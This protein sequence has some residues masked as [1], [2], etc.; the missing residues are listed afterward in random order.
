[1]DFTLLYLYAVAV[2]RELW[3]RKFLVLSCFFVVSFSVLFVGMVWPVKYETSTTIYA[4]NQNILRPLLANQAAT[5]EVQDQTRVVRDV[6]HSPRILRQIV[7]KVYGPD[8][9]ESV[10]ELEQKIQTVRSNLTVNGLG[11]SYIKISYTGESADTAYDILNGVT[12]LFIKDSASTQRNE[13]KEAFNFIDGQVRQYK[14]Q[15]VAAEQRLK[16]FESMNV[17]GRDTDVDSR[18][19]ALLN[20]IEEIKISNSELDSRIASLNKQ[21]AEEEQ[22]SS[23]SFKSDVYKERL[24]ELRSRL[25]TLRQT[26]KD[27]YPDVV[28][29]KMQITDMENVIREADQERSASPTDE[30]GGVV[31]PLYEELRSMLAEAKLSKNERERRLEATKNLLEDAL[32][33]RKRI[34]SRQAE[35]AEL[36]RD[37][38]VTQRIYEDMLER[39]ERARLSMTLN[40]EGQGVAYRV[41]E[42]AEYPMTSKGLRFLHFVVAGPVL[43]GLMPVGLLLGFILIDPRIRFATDLARISSVPVLVEVPHMMTPFSK[44]IVRTDMILVAVLGVLMIGA[45]LGIAFAHRAGVF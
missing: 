27:S 35:Q 11:A 29:V 26:Y 12:D 4:D 19:S 30:L 34:A 2:L 15:L 13:S 24:T 39:K 20:T 43:G 14:A 42:P 41:Q 31:N 7:E 38:T 37:Y 45:Y 1:M 10:V 3:N 9:F 36:L 33:R 5:T 28:S 23:R 22:Y 8:S 6:I 44:R 18:I 21:L 17:D 16:E 25:H 32:E 40:V